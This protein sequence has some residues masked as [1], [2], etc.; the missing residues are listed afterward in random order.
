MQTKDL[1]GGSERNHEKYISVVHVL[2]EIRTRD[3]PIAKH[4]SNQ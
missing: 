3:I 1:F 4:E 2:A